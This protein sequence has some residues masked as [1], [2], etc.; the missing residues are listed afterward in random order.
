MYE[1]ATL[2]IKAHPESIKEARDF[3][4]LTFGTWG[5]EDFL[6]RIVVSELATNAVKHGSREDDLVVVRT[7]RRDDGCAVIEAWDRSD[8]VPA[9]RPGDHASESGRGLLLLEQLVRRWGTRPLAEGGKVV[10]AELEAVP[11]EG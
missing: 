1:A 11:N 5:L 6:A 2:V 9:L 10:F 7:Y 4:A 3:V 8:A